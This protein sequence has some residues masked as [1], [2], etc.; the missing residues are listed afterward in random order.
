MG[1]LVTALIVASDPALTEE[2]LIAHCR[3]RLA[4]YRCP[5]RIVSVDSLARTATGRLQHPVAGLGMGR[6]IVRGDYEAA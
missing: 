6:G 4:G 1:E 3:T 2:E 5:K